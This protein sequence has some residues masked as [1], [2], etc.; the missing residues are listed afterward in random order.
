MIVVG[1]YNAIARIPFRVRRL[2]G[3]VSDPVFRDRAGEPERMRAWFR[4][5]YQHPEEHRHTLGEVQ[6]WF[7]ENGVEYLRS[8]PSALLDGDSNELFEPAPDN[9][10]FEG[11]LAQLGWIR[12]LGHEGGLFVTIG[13]RN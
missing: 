1:L 7:A 11:W 9:W 10:R 8:Y 4:D 2:F 5:Q 12:S 3:R 13:R 6:G